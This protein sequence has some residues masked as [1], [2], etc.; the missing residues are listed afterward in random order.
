MKEW[1][2]KNPFLG[3][4]YKNIGDS[5]KKE[6]MTHPHFEQAFPIMKAV[7]GKKLHWMCA[8]M[9]HCGLRMNEAAQITSRDYVEIRGIKCISALIPSA[10]LPVTAKLIWSV[11]NSI[12]S[13]RAS[14]DMK[15]LAN[16]LRIGTPS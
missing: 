1:I 13:E 11:A 4:R 8:L 15:V 3:T 7:E 10:V 9:H 12:A 6:P 5:K 14:V 2:S 16:S